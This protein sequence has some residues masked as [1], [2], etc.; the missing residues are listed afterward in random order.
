MG[1]GL[2]LSTAAVLGATAVIPVAVAADDVEDIKGGFYTDGEF[3][4][5]EQFKDKSRSEKGAVLLDKNAV[6]VYKSFED[7][8]IK[9]I[10]ARLIIEGSDQ[11]LQDAEVSATQYAEENGIIFD[12]ENGIIQSEDAIFVV[13]NVQSLN[14]TGVVVILKKL[15]EDVFDASVTV[16][17][18]DNNEVPVEEL[19]LSEGESEVEFKFINAYDSFADL[20][21]GVWTVNG[22]E[23]D[24]GAVFAVDA[25]K[26]A[27]NQIELL[28]ALQSDYFEHVDEDLIAKYA[29]EDFSG[30]KTVEDV[31]DIIDEVNEKN[32][33]LT[34]VKEAIIAVGTSTNQI[35]LLSALEDHFV[36]V[37]A[38]WIELY[39][40]GDNNVFFGNQN[41]GLLDFANEVREE[42][43][44][45]PD[46][47]F[48]DAPDDE[49]IIELF[50]EIQAF[51]DEANFM[52]IGLVSIEA[53]E[54][55]SNSGLDVAEGL[56]N[57][58]M[59]PDHEN[60]EEILEAIGYIRIVIA[61]NN[62]TTNNTLKSNLRALAEHPLTHGDLDMDTVNDVLLK[63]YREAIK[64]TDN[65]DKLEADMIQDI[66]NNVNVKAIDDAV[67]NVEE[68]FNA[69]EMNNDIPVKDL[70]EN[71]IQTLLNSLYRL[72]DVTI[73]EETNK[74]LDKDDIIAEY[75]YVVRYIFRIQL[76]SP[77]ISLQNIMQAIGVA[78]GDIKSGIEDDIR[79]A[80]EDGDADGLLEALKG[81]GLNNVKEEN[82]DA[83]V[84]APV[85][86][87]QTPVVNYFEIVDP[88]DF[89][90]VVNGVNAFVEANNAI[91][92]TELRSALTKLAVA[93]ESVGGIK[94]GEIYINLSNI[95]K[96]E[97]AEIMLNAKED[98]YEDI[99]DLGTALNDAFDKHETFLDNVNNATGSINSM[100][101]A[102][103][104]KHILP[105]FME[106]GGSE[107]VDIAETVF[108]K[109]HELDSKDPK[110]KFE[111]VTQIKEVAG[112]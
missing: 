27:S 26:N 70:D 55:L 29:D 66:I 31:Q 107:Q 63:E 24:L 71:E 112:L 111:S 73:N 9:A 87:N 35:N 82:K 81:F 41:M 65:L 68:L 17:D 42:L 110:E 16:R 83:Y 97:L 79:S 2:K 103:N 60:K 89:Q 45:N 86:K 98:D 3:I 94:E 78:N 64:E 5:I 6:Y 44:T 30:V 22:K 39:A 56:I 36:R 33:S 101:T 51:I 48:Q 8:E 91:T 46:A 58:Y 11:D 49:A 18:P 40:N 12:E 67:E 61:V 109:L 43:L 72:A 7:G 99:Y 75:N 54:N 38:D 74:R 4:S 28:A 1:K 52:E 96:L 15:S 88:D 102:L 23:Y 105:S 13:E 62:A 93:V 85:N 53:Y 90:A 80:S 77:N 59:N 69:V 20:P 100:R 92:A 47:F 50:E 108:N 25:V 10:P 37:N 57:D 104:N 95:V 14:E 32:V 106:L 34:K 84:E 19:D 21:V 76:A